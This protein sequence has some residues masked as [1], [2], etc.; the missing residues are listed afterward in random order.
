MYDG[1]PNSKWELFEGARHMC[2]VEDNPRYVKLLS[3]W[4]K[5]H[6]N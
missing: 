4:L 3:E 2:F 1:I 6:D 5:E